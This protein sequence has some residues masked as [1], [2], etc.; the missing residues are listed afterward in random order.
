[1]ATSHP[2]V[3]PSAPDLLDLRASEAFLAPLAG[4]AEGSPHT[5]TC[6]GLSDEDWLRLGVARTL[7]SPRSGRGFLQTFTPHLGACPDTSHFFEILK[8]PRRAKLVADVSGQLARRLPELEPGLPDE[9][10][11]Y[12]LHAGDGHW[13][14]AAAHD[15]PIDE[16][17]WAVGH[18]YSLNLRTRALAH[19]G[20]AEGKK[21]HDMGAIKRL[22]AELFRVGAPTGRQVLWIW[23]RAGIDFQLW[24]HWKHR[25]GIYFIS[26]VKENMRLEVVGQPRPDPAHAAHN[27]GVLADELVQTSQHVM[28]RRVRYQPAP[29]QSRQTEPLEFI[30]TC[31]ELPAGLVA[32]LYARRWELEK[33]FDQL[34]NKLEEGKAWA[35]SAEA[36]RTQAHF[37]CLT[38]NLLELLSRRLE[39]EQALRDEAGIKRAVRRRGH[40]AEAAAKAG[41]ALGA[42]VVETLRPLQLSV[43]FVRWLRAYWLSQ[44]PLSHALAHLRV[45]YARL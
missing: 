32:W 20:L 45:L 10:A 12:E 18:L 14:E 8:S 41:R 39:R 19:L 2:P 11:N 25:H 43:K 44:T 30:T 24:H 27:H 22:G 23:D 33:V 34:K 1:M 4:L 26:R 6:P 40:L 5:R 42:T 9:L 38:H 35:S 16:R 17:R 7:H 31:M 28:V 13:H 36:K 37:L 29:G 3:S 21:E 15:A